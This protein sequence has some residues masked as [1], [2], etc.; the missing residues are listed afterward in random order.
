MSPDCSWVA[1]GG[2]TGTEP[3]ITAHNVILGHA[4]AVDAYRKKYQ[5]TQGGVIG[6]CT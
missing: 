6:M 3:Y 4:K 2:D 1:D 5:A